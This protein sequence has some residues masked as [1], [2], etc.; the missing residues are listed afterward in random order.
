MSKINLSKPIEEMNRNECLEIIRS[1]AWSLGS[2][3]M[4]D[5]T[6][7]DGDTLI[8]LVNHLTAITIDVSDINTDHLPWN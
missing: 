5:Y 3:A 8:A 6:T 7:M 1:I 4:N 2:T